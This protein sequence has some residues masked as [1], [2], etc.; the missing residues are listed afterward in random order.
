MYAVKTE[1]SDLIIALE[2]INKSKYG[3]NV[4]FNRWPEKRGRRWCFTLRVSD[5][6]KDGARRSSSGR[7]MVSA[8]WHVHGDFFDALFKINPN[9]EIISL[10]DTINK[11]GGNWIDKNI[12][13][14]YMPLYHSSACECE[15][16]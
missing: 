9:A 8:C 10:G 4:T 7:R 11:D 3:G 16:F 15:D 1:H 5:S 6:S 14:V 12:G 2:E 13:S